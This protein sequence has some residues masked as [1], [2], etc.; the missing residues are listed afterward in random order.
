MGKNRRDNKGRILPK[1]ISQRPNGLYQIRITINGKQWVRYSRELQEAKKMLN[2][3]RAEIESGDISNLESLTLN[4]WYDRWLENYKKPLLKQRTY[5]NYVNYYNKNIRGYKIGKMKLEEIRPIHL[6]NHYNFLA[7][8]NDRPLAHSTLVY[9][10]SMVGGSLQEAVNNGLIKRN[11]A[12]GIMSKVV[13][14]EEKERLALTEEQVQKFLDFISDGRYAIYKNMFTVLFYS[15]LRVGELLALTWDD[16]DWERGLIKIDK[17]M[18][19][20]KLDGNAKKGFFITPPKTE[21]SNRMIPMLPNVKKALEEQKQL[22]LIF[23]IPNNYEITRF[24]KKNQLIDMCKGFIFTTSKGTPPTNESL[25]RTVKAII[26]AYNEEEKEHAQKE[27]RAPKLLP[28]FTMHS[29]RHSFTTISYRRGMRGLS[30]SALLGHRSEET[31]KKIY[32]HLDFDILKR[33]MEEAWG[34]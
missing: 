2:E 26:K 27:C 16:V 20:D 18:N 5:N 1:G 32:T 28:V 34:E 17:T 4:D 30:L 8:R 15:G 6:I 29:S 25:N 13:G 21:T 14:R 7:T 33:D 9:I 19:Y 10:N 22:Q 12:I 11:P 24:D 23:N 3:K 31:T